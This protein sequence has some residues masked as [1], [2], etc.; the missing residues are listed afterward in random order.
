LEALGIE[1]AGP[2]PLSFT[3]DQ[4]EIREFNSQFGQNRV[5]SQKAQVHFLEILLFMN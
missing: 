1:E 4:G 3:N 2:L 5:V